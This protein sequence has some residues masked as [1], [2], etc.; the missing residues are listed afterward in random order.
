MANKRLTTFAAVCGVIVGA[1]AATGLYEGFVVGQHAKEIRSI[2]QDLA[3]ARAELS[4]AYADANYALDACQRLISDAID[5]GAQLDEAYIDGRD[6]MDNFFTSGLPE[7]GDADYLYFFLYS[8]DE[9]REG[10][11]SMIEA[12]AFDDSDC[13]AT[14]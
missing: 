10:A 11:G 6:A 1:G 2:E 7:A 9:M 14:F 5:A 8:A 3:V 4:N 12:I 13:Y